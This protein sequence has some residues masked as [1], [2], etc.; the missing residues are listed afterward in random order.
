[1]TEDTEPDTF[2]ARLIRREARRR[3]ALELST[4]KP[5]SVLGPKAL[6]IGTSTASR[7]RPIRMRPHSGLLLRGSNVCQAPPR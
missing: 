5:T 7:P 2:S 6:L 1:M 4:V 3:A